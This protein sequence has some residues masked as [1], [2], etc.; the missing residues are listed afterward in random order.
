MQTKKPPLPIAALEGRGAEA[1]RR[2]S[3]LQTRCMASGKVTV[4]ARNWAR[5]PLLRIAGDIATTAPPAAA[6]GP[7]VEAGDIG[8]GGSVPTG[9]LV[10]PSPAHPGGGGLDPGPM[11]RT[12]HRVSHHHHRHPSLGACGPLPVDRD[13]DDSGGERV[14]GLPSPSI[15]PPPR[16]SGPPLPGPHGL[17]FLRNDT[18]GALLGDTLRG[19]AAKQMQGGGEAGLSPPPIEPE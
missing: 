19:L 3:G 4:V 11:S 15:P 13:G 6:I 7:L 12:R 18:G 2:R 10:S 14:S 8:G 5:A 9:G 17:E 1:W 16:P